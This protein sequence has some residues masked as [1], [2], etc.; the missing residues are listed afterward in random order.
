MV[1]LVSEDFAVSRVMPTCVAY[2][3]TWWHGVIRAQASVTGH[4]WVCGPAVA[5]V[6]VDICGS[7]CHQG[8][9]RCLGS[10]QQ[11]EILLMS[12]N[13]EA[14]GAIQTRVACAPTGAMKTSRPTCCYVT[15][16]VCGPAVTGV[17]AIPGHR[18]HA[19][20]ILRP[21]LLVGHCSKIAGSTSHGRASSCT[22]RNGP[23]HHQGH[24]IAGPRAL[25]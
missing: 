21:V 25:A 10:G 13:F 16:W 6:W 11:P 22:W 2:T 7:C 19:S 14:T 23:I 20:W 8:M 18:N 12:E 17:C 3:A 24:G 15:V 9:C 4:V 1:M 5:R